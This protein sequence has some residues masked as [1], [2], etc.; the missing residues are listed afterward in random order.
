MRYGMMIMVT[1]LVAAGGVAEPSGHTQQTFQAHF[2]DVVQNERRRLKDTGYN[3][4]ENLV[5]PRYVTKLLLPLAR[6]LVAHPK[7]DIE[8][9]LEIAQKKRGKE[10]EDSDRLAQLTLA[11]LGN[12]KAIDYLYDLI[13]QD[14]LLRPENVELLYYMPVNSLRTLSHRLAKVS[15]KKEYRDFGANMLAR[16][17]DEQS[18]PVLKAK[19]GGATPL[20]MDSKAITEIEWRNKNVSKKDRDRWYAMEMTYQL[21][22]ERFKWTHVADHGPTQAARWLKANASFTEPFLS[23]K[24]ELG[25]PVALRLITFLGKKEMIPSVLRNL[26]ANSARKTIRQQRQYDEAM[27]ALIG[28]GYKES[29]ALILPQFIPGEEGNTKLFRRLCYF[30]EK[31]GKKVLEALRKEEGF[32]EQI[33]TMERYLREMPEVKKRIEDMRNMGKKPKSDPI[34]TPPL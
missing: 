31:V 6:K 29:L 3:R 22:I 32:K 17:G 1:L 15:K 13:N 34:R 25:D 2:E 10:W 5:I 16:I 23:R 12:E 30:N 33:P 4:S 11:C 20:D 7:I 9:L 21:A 24:S 8:Y 27:W 18:I 28:L 19:G 14:R 26:K